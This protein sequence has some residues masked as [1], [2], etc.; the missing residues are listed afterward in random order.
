MKQIQ[1]VRL[2]FTAGSSDKEYRLHL[3]EDKGSYVVNF[4]YGRRNGTLKGGTKTSSPVSKAEAEKIF[5]K[6]LK[7]KTSEGYVLDGATATSTPSLT[8]AVPK[9]KDATLVQLLKEVKDEAELERMIKDPNYFMQEKQDGERRTLDKE[10]KE[11]SGGNKKGEKVGLSQSVIESITEKDIELDGELVGEILFVFD[12]LRLNNKDLRKFSYEERLTILESVDFG[13]NVFIVQ[14]ARTEAEKRTMAQRLKENN[15]EGFVL[16]EKNSGYN[17]GR[18]GSSAYKH[19]F[20]KT[21]T[22][23][24]V[25]ITKGKRSVQMAVKDGSEFV[26][27]GAVTIPPNKEVPKIGDYAEVR[28]LYAYKGGSLFQ[29]TFLFSRS[30]ADDSDSIIEQLEYKKEA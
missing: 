30:D 13:L 21:A 15:A 1:A 24:V 10:G 9:T 28:Y 6:Y 16:K 20:Y 23:K 7:E 5:N 26:E 19:K 4:Q 12:I 25:A 14:T 18:E 3:I 29:P 27:V 2:T 8:V 17:V 22:V 11:I